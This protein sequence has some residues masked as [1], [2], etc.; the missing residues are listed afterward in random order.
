MVD[1]TPE[2]IAKR[3]ADQ[4]KTIKENATKKGR[5]DVVAMC[6]IELEQRKPSRAKN[7]RSGSRN[8]RKLGQYVSEF[9]F[10]CPKEQGVTEDTNGLMWTGTWVVK[11]ENAFDAQTYGSLVALHTS[12]A[13]PS[14]LQGEIRGW[15]KSPRQKEYAEGQVA[16][17]PFGID[18]QFV[19]NANPIPW[20]GDA[21]GEK[22]YLWAEVPSKVA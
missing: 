2:E 20:Q 21:A 22:G 18:F 10:I 12:K 6:E 4:I 16:K 7:L 17:T 14:Y 13:E 5:G 8:D 1:W 3:S 11:E 19:P 9:H 15:R